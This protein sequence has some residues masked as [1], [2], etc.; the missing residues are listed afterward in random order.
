MCAIQVKYI[1]PQGGV[2]EF[3]EQHGV[4]ASYAVAAVAARPP[5]EIFYAGIELPTGEQV[6]L[7]VNRQSQL[8]CLDIVDHGGQS[9]Y[10]LLRHTVT[11]PLLKPLDA[12]T[13]TV[14]E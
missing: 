14:A 13:K 9:G 4:W 2:V 7:T 5:P 1:S 10:E 11:P 3:N 8:V 12:S 6:Q